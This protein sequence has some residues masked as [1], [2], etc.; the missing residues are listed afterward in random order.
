[1]RLLIILFGLIL[2]FG[3][4]SRIGSGT[5]LYEQDYKDNFQ[6]IAIYEPNASNLCKVGECLCMVCKNGTNIFGPI[7]SLVGGY[8]YFEKNCTANKTGE[9]SLGSPPYEDK[10]IRHFMIGQGPT[11]GDFSTANTYCN[12]RLSMAVQW[13]I[14]DNETAYMEPDASR[15]M[16]FL[17]KDIIPV[18]IL[19]SNGTAMDMM[20]ETG[21][22]ADILGT[23]G[24]SL[25][26][27]RLSSGPVG[28]V[29]VIPEINFDVSHAADVAQQIHIINSACQNNRGANDIHCITAVGPKM[30]DV[31]ALDAVMQELKANGWQ[32]ELDL[33]AYG[34]DG[35]YARTCDGAQ[36]RQQAL[37]FSSY[38]LYNYSKPTLIPYVLF[39]PGTNDSNN[40][41]TWNE[42]SVVA[43]YGSFFPIGIQALQK[44]GVIGIAPYSFNTTGG[45][46]VVNPLNC[47][48]C[49]VART[50]DRL[51][52]WYGGCQMYTWYSREASKTNPSGGTL[53]IFGNES[54]SVCN[55][56]TQYDYLSAVRFAG[57]DISQQQQNQLNASQPKYFSCD[58]CIIN[59]ITSPIPFEFTNVRNDVPPD[60]YCSGFPE[61]DTWA[62][63][64]NL[65]PMLVRAFIITES[66]FDPCAAAKVCR[67]G[68]AGP[69]CFDNDPATADECYYQGYNKMEDPTGNCTFVN[70]PNWDTP[71]PDWRWCGLG[72]MQ[73]L[74]PPYTFWPAAFAPGGVDGPL[75]SVYLASH[76]ADSELAN[77]KSCNPVNFN[78]FNPSDSACMGTLK[79][80]AKLK[81]AKKWIFDNRGKLNWQATDSEK[82]SVFAAYIAAHKYGGTWDAKGTTSRKPGHPRCASTMKN[83][84]CWAYGFSQSWPY[85]AAY[86]GTDAGRADTTRC[87]NGA[88]IQ[89]PPDK[90]Y[91]YTDFIKFVR[92]CEVPY[93]KSGRD[94]GAVKMQNFFWLTTNCTN[95]MCPD[96]KALYAAMQMTVPPSGTPYLP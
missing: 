64:R 19:Y 28:P 51:R 86:C 74:E 59:N 36:V 66:N 39:D 76:P 90:C 80:E 31:A 32:N 45:T 25:Y 55:H 61:I 82:D 62:G 11:F 33:V 54:G 79:L 65:D 93:L 78:P 71:N 68:Y 43:A 50:Q 77:A 60:L 1:M 56:N 46:G 92:D 16:C 91:G 24:G 29:I 12:N 69:G 49:A 10:L 41:C 6:R 94:S 18:Y 88:P 38:A 15:A 81:D 23:D 7:K 89:Q 9:I 44:R 30:N 67:A 35:R 83:G 48:N 13:L 42:Y 26:L 4:L 70:A 63:S 75:A 17:S 8:C 2:F 58:A 73:S 14:G 22:I 85:D 72:I 27:G 37:N 34:I 52:S 20:A 95:S 57:R 96:G 21:K 3:C 53:L 5:T 84:D 47:T 40:S 87:D